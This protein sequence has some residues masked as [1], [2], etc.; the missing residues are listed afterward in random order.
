MVAQEALAGRVHPRVGLATHYHADYVVPYWADSLNKIVQIGRHIFYKLRGGIGSSR[1][2]RQRYAGVEPPPPSAGTSAA[3]LEEALKVT[4][5][6]TNPLLPV[7]EEEAPKPIMDDIPTAA[8]IRP[9]TA[10]AIDNAQGSLILDGDT[11]RPSYTKRP[12]SSAGQSS[13]NAANGSN[14]VSA[15][16]ANDLRTGKPTPDC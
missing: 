12:K 15:I 5:E 7:A 1:A 16:K 8:E 6:T 2:F 13:C 3:V 10:L 11:P 4:E 9:E 14:S